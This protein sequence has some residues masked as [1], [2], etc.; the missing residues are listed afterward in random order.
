MIMANRSGG[1][2]QRYGADTDQSAEQPYGGR[3]RLPPP[4]PQPLPPDAGRGPVLRHESPDP[5]SW[6]GLEFRLV[7]CLHS[8][9]LEPEAL[10]NPRLRNFVLMH[11]LFSEQ[12][13]IS[14]LDTCTQPL[15][16][17][18]GDL[19]LNYCVSYNLLA[20][21]ASS[22]LLGALQSADELLEVK[23]M[24]TAAGRL[25]MSGIAQPGTL[26][27]TGMA[28]LPL[29]DIWA[30]RRGDML[31]ERIEVIEDSDEMAT[32][33]ILTVSLVAEAALRT[34]RQQQQR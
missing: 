19:Q 30:G 32:V 24:S 7:L 1:G 18:Q 9:Q 3:A 4:S 23:L 21:T 12:A 15:P 6:T 10:R 17:G 11:S 16:K 22:E 33:A 34:L 20:G 13:G 5:A 26:Q 2:R 25:D 29:A 28:L 14:E 27:T 8:L 31:Q